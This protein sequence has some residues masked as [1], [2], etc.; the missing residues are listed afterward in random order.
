[1]KKFIC[2]ITGHKLTPLK[3]N[4]L[5]SKDYECS[6]CQQQFTTDGYGRTVKLNSYWQENNMLFEILLEKRK[7]KAS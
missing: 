6:S 1:M 3:K 4:N 2:K 7:A 5:L